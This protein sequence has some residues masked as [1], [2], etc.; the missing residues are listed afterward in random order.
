MEIMGR[1][2]ATNLHLPP[3]MQFR[4]GAYY[5]ITPGRDGA[6][7]RWVRLGREY[8]AAL[9]QWAELRG[10]AASPGTTVGSAMDQYLAVSVASLAERTQKDY[11][12]YIGRLRPVLGHLGIDELT[13]AVIRQYRDAKQS[14]QQAR[15]ELSC[16]RSVYREAREWGWTENDPFRGVRMPAI[17]RRRRPTELAEFIRLRQAAGPAL[18]CV[19]DFGLLTALRKGDILKVRLADLLPDGIRVDVSKTGSYRLIAWTDQLREVVARA[20]ALRR[21]RRPGANV[22]SLYLFVST[23]SGGPYTDSGFNTVWRRAVGRAGLSDLRPHDMR[24][25]ALTEAKRR[26]GSDYAQAL[27]AHGS[28]T[29]TEGYIRSSE[30]AVVVPLDNVTLE[31]RD[32]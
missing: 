1:R 12:L 18:Q 13:P 21:R 9:R 22:D 15:L 25:W 11:R 17:A 26:G 7:R 32:D 29:T 8:G 30:R 31:T 2:R 27:A 16:L 6:R 10:E 5:L 20:K 24:S 3:G 28:V 4:H 14:K 19:I 23:R